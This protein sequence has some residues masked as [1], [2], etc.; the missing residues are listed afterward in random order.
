MCVFFRIFKWSCRFLFN[1]PFNT[2]LWHHFHNRFKKNSRPLNGRKVPQCSQSE[3]E[4]Q[5]SYPSNTLWMYWCEC[6]QKILDNGQILMTTQQFLFLSFFGYQSFYRRKRTEKKLEYSA[7]SRTN[8]EHIT[9]THTHALIPN[10][11]I[12][13]H[14]PT[15]YHTIQ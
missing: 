13:L 5:I 3:R 14:K 15:T 1:F 4:S 12:P 11:P 9:H 10:Q 8:V 2:Y 7:K 6:V